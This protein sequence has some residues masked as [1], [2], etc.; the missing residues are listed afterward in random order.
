MK[1]F[2]YKLFILLLLIAQAGSVLAQT[3]APLG[4]LDPPPPAIDASR[5]IDDPGSGTYCLLEPLPCIEGTGNNCA[6]GSRMDQINIEG[7]ISYVYKLF[8]AVGV[9]LAVVMIIWGGFEWML[10]AI[11]FVKLHAKE[12]ISNA[13]WG[14]LML[15][16]SYLILQTI[17]PRLV[18][19]TTT[20]PKLVFEPCAEGELRNGYCDDSIDFVRGVEEQLGAINRGRLL[21]INNMERKIQDLKREI[22]GLEGWIGDPSLKAAERTEKEKEL[23]E[24]KVELANT[25]LNQYTT[26]TA[27]LGSTH[28]KSALP[29]IY[30]PV[31][32]SDE[33]LRQYLKNP[34]NHNVQVNGKL[35]TNTGNV[36]ADQYNKYINEI[37]AITPQTENMNT[38]V[39][40]LKR[41]KYFYL[42]QVEEDINFKELLFVSTA[43]IGDRAPSGN[44]VS[45]ATIQDARTKIDAKKDE[46]AANIASANVKIVAAGVSE[47]EYRTIME[48]RLNQINQRNPPK[49]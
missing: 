46:Y 14:L 5:C 9:F 30:R 44:T 16:S 17:D 4:E 26:I 33:T 39:E 43:K 23:Q 40:K 10:S 34:G 27:G 13:I 3:A 41:Q 38:E 12:R 47:V 15:L 22:A 18:N 45:A 2:T 37:R 7:Y 48:G 11:P 36:I 32:E 8:L 25:Q 42:E 20:V 28:Y 49:P 6:N 19:V 24:K 1:H 31:N 35:P 21:E 29:H